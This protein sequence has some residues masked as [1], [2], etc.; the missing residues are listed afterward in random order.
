MLPSLLRASSDGAL[1]VAAV[2]L[3]TRGV[4]SLSPAART[5]LWWIAAAKF[6]VALVWITPVALPILPAER[7]AAMAGTTASGEGELQRTAGASTV[8]TGVRS[9][10]LAT[11]GAAADL[12]RTMSID[13]R[14]AAVALW[15]AGVAAV[16]IRSVRRWQRMDAV[17]RSARP[18]APAVREL[19]ADLA[20]RIGLANP[21]EVR[22][23]GDIETPLVTG[24]LR[25]TVLVPGRF[26]ALSGAQQEMALC[27][28]LM[29]L[30]RRDLW[31]GGVPA[32]AGHLFFF[33]PAV[34]VA[35]REYALWRE[36]ACDAAVLAALGCAPQDYG[37]LLLDLGITP[38]PTGLSAAGTSWSFSSLK[39]R[40]AMLQN[41]TSPSRIS[42][43]AA[44]TAIVL[45][46]GALL[47]VQLRARPSVGA[48]PRDAGATGSFT[49][50]VAAEAAAAAPAP[51]TPQEREDARK[52]VFFVNDDQTIMSGSTQ[53]AERARRFKR[54]GE[55]MMWFRDGGREYV[56]R[57]REILRQ[58]ESVWRPVSAFGHQQGTVG[59]QQGEIGRLQG[60]IGS[61]MGL[62]GQ[63]Q[64]KI[65]DRQAALSR[66]FA[67]DERSTRSRTGDAEQ[68]QRQL[69]EDMRELDREM[70][71]L[72]GKM[73][74][75]DAPMRELD[76]R[77][78]VLD[79][80]MRAL[81]G[82]LQEAEHRALAAMRALLD[83]AIG[84]GG[85][86]P[87]GN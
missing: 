65:G 13:W 39:R 26:D 7:A 17:R 12:M 83:R 64:A 4:R 82:K 42:R 62:V 5:V 36:S 44:A 16:T 87:V 38:R 58:V 8:A 71:V 55:T 23:S 45:A 68:A 79:E 49:A 10:A 14:R 11:Q 9:T 35:T 51:E 43:T 19:A 66:R 59:E 22:C 18:A 40:I 61:K 80:E 46:V 2:W 70:R 1:I 69:D 20:R 47:P 56:I 25:P 15:I 75:L 30:K 76:D 81:D 37:R 57:D 60:D 6:I 31:L 34:L 54:P 74:D 24:I 21:P 86:E 84:S 78:R 28:E 67:D 77:M 72:D 3:I 85:A 53:D 50:T 29:H 33:H 41:A 73:R 32:L 27:H 48:S 63:E 52:F